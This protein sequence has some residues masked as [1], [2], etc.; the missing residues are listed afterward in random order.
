MTCKQVHYYIWDLY[1]ATLTVA[2]KN[3]ERSPFSRAAGPGFITI[4]TLPSASEAVCQCNDVPE[5]H[6]K[7]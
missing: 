7:R 2:T 1:H 3:L 4:F 5:T 6:V